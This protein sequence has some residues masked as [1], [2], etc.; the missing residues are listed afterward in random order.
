MRRFDRGTARAAGFVALLVMVFLTVNTSVAAAADHAATGGA[1]L[2]APLNVTTS[3]GAP[4]SGYELRAD[5]GDI[6]DVTRQF[7]TLIL[8][9]LFS[10]VR[11]LVGLACWLIGFAFKF[12]LLTAMLRPAQAVSDAYATHVVGAIGL[13]GVL[14]SWAF[15]FGLILVA[16]G[17]VGRGL[18]EI[19]L[20]LVIAA[21]AAS[22][23]VRPDYLLAKDGPLDQT[24]QAAIELAAITSNSY[25]GS[26][27]TSGPGSPACDRVDRPAPASCTGAMATGGVD[28]AKSVQDALTNALVVK[29]FQLLQYGRLLDDGKPENRAAYAAHL[30]MVKSTDAD[31]DRDS[32]ACDR[33]PGPAKDYCNGTATS[34][35]DQSPEDAKFSALLD[36]LEDASDVGKQAA[37]YARAPSWDRIGG[38][39]LLGIAAVVVTAMAVSL[40]LI[41][42]GTQAADV[43]AAAVGGITFIWGMLPGPSRMA[44]WRWLGVFLASVMVMFATAMT[45][46]MFGIGIDA[47]LT[48]SGAGPMVERLLLLDAFAIAALAFHR[49]LMAATSQFGQ[50]L[51]LRMR[52]A[53]VGGTHLPGDNSELGAAI[54]AHL[55][56]L[57]GGGLALGRGGL[58][59]PHGALLLRHR[60]LSHALAMTDGAGMPA[61]T[62]RLAGDAL[63]E[64]RRGLAPLGMAVTAAALGVRG[65]YGTLI[66]RRP[67]DEA[68]ARMRR[69]VGPGEEDAEGN[70]V[71]P[72]EPMVAN[73]HTG[74][75]LHDPDQHRTLLSTRFH[76][77]AVRFRGYRIA[78]RGALVAYGATLG[79]PRSASDT[80]RHASEFT[81]DALHQLRVTGG[82]LREDVDDWTAA[83]RDVGRGAAHVGQRLATAIDVH[84][85]AMRTRAFVRDAAVG[86]WLLGASSS[87]SQAAPY[88]PRPSGSLPD[89][90]PAS[91]R[92]RVFE[93][94]MEA[95]RSLWDWDD[96]GGDRR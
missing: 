29:P 39:L 23:F 38:V 35:L 53:K 22:V 25:F 85:P 36:E 34:P 31:T 19:L 79:L 45:I 27:P 91:D 55:S 76:N 60:F 37:D 70:V 44:V 6:T 47:L 83:G 28:V 41:L 51:A 87:G 40:A 16:R 68:L 66:G 33:I 46:P 59:A 67:D 75:L 50:R 94:L 26:T 11:L 82:R 95:Q 96:N 7:Q 93:A 20:T 61:D 77:R 80:R 2:L 30:K 43:G 52:Y 54:G 73:R 88:D 5:G 12:P 58:S 62:G 81:Q 32:S 3:E 8:G 65:A 56:N 14:L 21:L 78:R 9:G 4:L 42:L 89:T 57:G 13:E 48:S 63:A 72:G 74:E 18:G 64:A 69:P 86:G 24:H 17:K 92:R 10:L 1:G 49:R 84:D 71:T 90:G 15:V